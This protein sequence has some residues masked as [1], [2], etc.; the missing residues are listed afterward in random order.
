VIK[1]FLRD[2][3]DLRVVYEAAG[4]HVFVF[5]LFRVE[6]KDDEGYRSLA[7]YATLL[8]MNVKVGCALDLPYMTCSAPRDEKVVVPRLE[9]QV[10]P[11]VAVTDVLRPT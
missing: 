6:G 10:D 7:F 3:P 9:E 11:L 8:E 5:S 1:P 2:A 4:P